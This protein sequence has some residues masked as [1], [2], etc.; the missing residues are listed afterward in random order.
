MKTIFQKMPDLL[1]HIL[2]G[3]YMYKAP[4]YGAYNW[5]SSDAIKILHTYMHVHV[6]LY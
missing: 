5:S 3:R 6:L 1:N 2:L 4:I